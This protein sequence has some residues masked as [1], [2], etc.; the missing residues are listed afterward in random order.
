MDRKLQALLEAAGLDPGDL[1]DPFETWLGLHRAIGERATLIERYELEAASRGVGVGDLKED[2]RMRMRREVLP[3]LF[4]G[5]EE[6]AGVTTPDPIIV[7]DYDPTWQTRF[8]E[9]AGCLGAALDGIG[10]V[11]EHIGSTAVGGLAA[12][13]VIDIMVAVP[14]AADEAAYVSSI[15]SC[16]VMLRSRDDGHR[17][18][19]PQPP[20]RR[21]VQ[22][23]VVDL[24][25]D[26]QHRHLLFRDYLCAHPDA[27]AAY[28]DLKKNLAIRYRYDRLAYNAAK[29]GFILD[30][31]AK[32]E[33]WRISP[34]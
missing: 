4:P 23:H 12:K 10:P 11:I 29:T 9:I 8:K 24:G 27:V 3:V 7:V 34:E 26:W 17:Y 6:A 33:R 32:A 30:E 20:Q 25:S 14:D 31:M 19:R 18:F 16:G 13:P 21:T 5:W 2:D 1:A 15:E 28:G 22:I